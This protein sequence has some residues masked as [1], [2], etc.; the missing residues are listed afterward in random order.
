MADHREQE[1]LL[2]DAAAAAEEAS[3]DIETLLDV[4]GLPLAY[5]GILV[6]VLKEGSWQ[7]SDSPIETVYHATMNAVPRS[8]MQ[9]AVLGR[10]EQGRNRRREKTG[11]YSPETLGWLYEKAESRRGGREE[12]HELIPQPI[13]H[14]PAELRTTSAVDSR[15][16]PDWDKIAERS[17]LDEWETRA[18]HAWARG[19]TCYRAMQALDDAADKRAMEAAWRRL[20]RN[21][22]KV[23]GV[24]GRPGG[25]TELQPLTDQDRYYVLPGARRGMRPMG[26]SAVL[27]AMRCL[28]IGKEEMTGHGFRAVAFWLRVGR[29]R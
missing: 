29:A 19:E 9:R 11:R 21:L 7:T 26:D 13:E 23:R 5:K 3:P 15:G 6:R 22:H 4:F 25:E 20:R 2:L 12:Q 14:V 28:G 8:A 27:A 24:L 17:G 16:V 10:D 1:I 18:L